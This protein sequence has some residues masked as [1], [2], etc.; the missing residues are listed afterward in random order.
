MTAWM[1]G[2][3]GPPRPLYT[4]VYPRTRAAVD[5]ELLL[6]RARAS[7]G[8]SMYGMTCLA[9]IHMRIHMRTET[10]IFADS[11]QYDRSGPPLFEWEMAPIA[12]RPF[13]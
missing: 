2:A 8:A 3:S 12:L 5:K 13:K 6:G 1:T 9:P 7:H 4:A 11:A 10:C